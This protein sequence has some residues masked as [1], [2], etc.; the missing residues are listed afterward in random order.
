MEEGGHQ[1]KI[2]VIQSAW[3]DGGAF[4]A[5]AH[6]LWRHRSQ[7]GSVEWTLPQSVPLEMLA[8]E[9]R[10]WREDVQMWMGRPVNVPKALEIKSAY[11]AV[12]TPFSFSLK[13]PVIPENNGSYFLEGNSVQFRKGDYS[14]PELGFSVFSAMIL[15][16]LSLEEGK[17]AGLVGEDFPGDKTYLSR[18]ENI[19]ITKDF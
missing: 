15:G 12:G 11:Q 1:Q 5:L 9:P 3:S 19:C 4:R 13:D 2:A 6:F 18:L 8:Q 16:G 7:V 17:A 10:I 14:A